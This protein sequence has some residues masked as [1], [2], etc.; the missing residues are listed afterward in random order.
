[1]K[2]ANLPQNGNFIMNSSR[3]IFIYE[4]CGKWVML[5]NYYT[6]KRSIFST[7]V[8]Q[9]LWKNRNYNCITNPENLTE[10]NNT[11]RFASRLIVK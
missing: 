1:M 10:L 7:T 2:N 3:E 11:M 9:Q 5:T 8:F 6:N 4:D